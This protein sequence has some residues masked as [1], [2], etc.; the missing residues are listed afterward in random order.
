MGFLQLVSTSIGEGFQ[1][2]DDWLS[3]IGEALQFV[4]AFSGRAMGFLQL[5]NAAICE[6]GRWAFFNR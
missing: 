4:R 6:G 5:V 3:S 1:W 2:A